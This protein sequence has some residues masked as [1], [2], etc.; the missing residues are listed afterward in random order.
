MRAVV[1]YERGGKY[2]VRDVPMPRLND[3][4]VLIKISHAALCYRDLLQL[5]GYY[6]R[7]KYP[8]HLGS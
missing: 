1:V 2:E 3:G 7:M 4:D 5:A 8:R 6:P